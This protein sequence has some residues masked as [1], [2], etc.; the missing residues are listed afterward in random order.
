[1]R[2]TLLAGVCLADS[3]T[4][5]PIKLSGLG[6]GY[7][8]TRNVTSVAGAG[9][10][11]ICIHGHGGSYNDF[12]FIAEGFAQED[13]ALYS[14]DFDGEFSAF[15][16][17]I[18]ERQAEFA[19]RVVKELCTEPSSNCHVIGHSMGGVVAVE[20]LRYPV[21]RLLKSVH[22]LSTPLTS[23]PAPIDISWALFYSRLDKLMRNVKT[24]LWSW[25]TGI[26][27]TMVPYESSLLPSHSRGKSFVS[28]SL[29][30]L[31]LILD[32]WGLLFDYGFTNTIL[33]PAVAFGREPLPSPTSLL[34]R[35]VYT[36]RYTVP[37]WLTQET[38]CSATGPVRLSVESSCP[39]SHLEIRGST[40]DNVMI[41]D[42]KGNWMQ[43]VTA[44]FKFQD[45]REMT[46]GT[47]RLTTRITSIIIP[48]GVSVT[49]LDDNTRTI[50]QLKL[51]YSSL[52]PIVTVESEGGAVSQHGSPGSSLLTL[53]GTDSVWVIGQMQMHVQYTWGAKYL[54]LRHW[55]TLIGYL[56]TAAVSGDS[57]ITLTMQTITVALLSA[58]ALHLL[59]FM[60]ACGLNL[61]L[62]LV[63]RVVPIIPRLPIADNLLIC[64]I[65]PG[66][67]LLMMSLQYRDYRQRRVV[68]LMVAIESLKLA[69]VGLALWQLTK[70]CLRTGLGYLLVSIPDWP[71]M[72]SCVF[73]IALLHRERQSVDMKLFNEELRRLWTIIVGCLSAAT[74]SIGV[75]IYWQ[76][77]ALQLV[78]VSHACFGYELRYRA[79]TGSHDESLL[80]KEQ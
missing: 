25:A 10:T 75:A 26:G 42:D 23:H 67:G 63:L 39:S 5:I 51:S 47:L 36:L 49:L 38:G 8:L 69:T 50:R 28:S 77:I 15:A 48:T 44:K 29:P 74:V 12:K 58:S 53:H 22:T 13:F 56:M 20:L 65:S 55:P 1:M 79:N 76:I 7:R 3:F 16:P 27:D 62:G 30:N 64:A 35:P 9:G 73:L 70:G 41:E 68:F 45:G 19:S 43:L 21:A 61:L 52:T 31:Y 80:V 72:A 11:V 32:H 33:V 60:T 71:G 59:L 37:S 54:A 46:A 40:D 34:V 18:I 2:F 17:G 78:L 57:L 24:P 66:I 4:W 14:L 6:E